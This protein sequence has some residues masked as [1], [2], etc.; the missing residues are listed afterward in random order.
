[1]TR[2]RLCGMEESGGVR[3]ASDFV[4]LQSDHGETSSKGRGRAAVDIGEG[5]GEG[6]RTEREE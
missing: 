6:G 3:G 5:S 4:G 2:T 1:M